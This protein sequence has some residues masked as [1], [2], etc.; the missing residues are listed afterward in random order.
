MFHLGMF[1]I[2]DENELSLQKYQVIQFIVHP[3]WNFSNERYIGDIALA[4]LSESVQFTK[5]V[6]PICIWPQ[7]STH[8]NLAGIYGFT[9]GYGITENGLTSSTPLFAKLPIVKDA[10]CLR[11]RSELAK[12]SDASN[13]CV[14]D[15]SG[16]SPCKGN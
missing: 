3:S 12:L 4:I 10:T 7:S 11:S 14:G 15:G 8:D 13:F 9:A 6:I 1:N 16:I 5:N 2:K